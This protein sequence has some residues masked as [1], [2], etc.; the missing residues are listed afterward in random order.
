MKK[1][2]IIAMVLMT[3]LASA[4]MRGHH[5]PGMGW[6]PEL[7]LTTEQI[8]QIDQFR[9]GFQKDRIDLQADVAKLRIE[10][11]ELTRADDPNQKAIN[12]VLEKI[13]TRE[14]ALEKLRVEHRLQVRGLLTEEQKV[15][16]D[17]Q[18]LGRGMGQKGQGRHDG[19][20]DGSGPKGMKKQGGGRW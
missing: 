2:I 9:S 5:D 3:A 14:L 20:C 19:V 4:Q 13:S 18:P 12:A 10:L 15:L 7:N 17:Q 1:Q 6:D 11:R 8:K 16:F